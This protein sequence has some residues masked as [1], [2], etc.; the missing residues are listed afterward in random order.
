MDKYVKKLVSADEQSNNITSQQ[1]ASNFTDVDRDTNV[2]V[3]FCD[4]AC[5]TSSR[6]N[7][8][9]NPNFILDHNPTVLNDIDNIYDFNFNF[10][11]NNIQ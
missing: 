5:E 4:F 2:N 3:N 7:S 1:N 10:D 9:H 11:F 8:Y 6:I